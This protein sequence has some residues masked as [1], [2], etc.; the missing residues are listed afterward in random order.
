[1]TLTRPECGTEPPTHD[2][3][4][5]SCGAQVSA[6]EPSGERGSA[7]V[8]ALKRLAPAEFAERQLVMW[9]QVAS[10]RRIVTM[11][12]SDVK[13]STPMAGKLDPGEVT[14]IMEGA[15]EV[16]REPVTRY[17]AA[18]ACLMGDGI[19][20]FFGAPIAREDDAERARRAALN[21]IA[22]AQHYAGEYVLCTLWRTQ[23]YDAP[24]EEVIIEPH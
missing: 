1:L 7:A 13:G 20:G 19:L 8:R 15:F 4:C 14:E 18:L 9:G 3:F 24:I 5:F 17:E 21:I 23:G 2:R 22:G 16:L 6:P 11:L 10:E 12:F